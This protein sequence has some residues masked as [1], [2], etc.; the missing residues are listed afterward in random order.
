[1]ELSSGF[2][3]A[4]VCGRASLIIGM[5]DGAVVLPWLRAKNWGMPVPGL[6]PRM[7]VVMMG[8]RAAVAV[9]RTWEDRIAVPPA[10]RE[11][12]DAGM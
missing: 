10:G 1:M 7:G 12:R 2:T 6:R 5:A 3:V 8:I 11:E 9:E 4:C